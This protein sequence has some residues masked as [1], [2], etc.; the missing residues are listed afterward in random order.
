MQEQIHKDISSGIIHLHDDKIFWDYDNRNILR[1]DISDIVIIGEYTNPD[2]PYFDDWFLTFV[3]KDGRWQSIP[4]YAANVDELIQ[5]LSDTFKQDINITYLANST[6]W[7]SVI[8]YPLRLKGKPLFKLALI[9]DYKAPK[10]FF[11]KILSSVGLGGLDTT[12]GVDLTDEVKNEL[13]NA[14]PFSWALR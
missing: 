11:D 1:I 12:S 2:G 14:S 13:K 3:T 10:T 4:Y 6:E 5:Y 7:K 8:R 9:E